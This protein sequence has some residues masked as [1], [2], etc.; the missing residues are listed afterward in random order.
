MPGRWMQKAA[1]KMEKKGTEGTFT[2]AAK[3]AGHGVQEYAHMKEHAKG[4]LG[5]R[6]RMALR[7]AEAKH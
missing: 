3:R 2:A 1:N 7:F 4:K 6:A 5:K